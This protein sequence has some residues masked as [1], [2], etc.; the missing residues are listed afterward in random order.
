MAIEVNA[1]SIIF[2][3]TSFPELVKRVERLAILEDRTRASMIR[4][5]LLRAVEGMESEQ[6]LPPLE[7]SNGD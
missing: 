6:G 7:G 2:D 4:R 5:L 3:L 1:M